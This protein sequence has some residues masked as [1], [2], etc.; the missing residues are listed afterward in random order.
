MDEKERNQPKVDLALKIQLQ[1]S[2][3][4]GGRGWKAFQKFIVVGPT[5]SDPRAPK[6]FNSIFVCS[7]C[8]QSRFANIL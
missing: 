6:F 7:G 8:I 1:G 2:L 5:T 4:K 3:N